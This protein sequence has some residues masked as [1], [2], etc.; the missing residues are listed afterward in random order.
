[1]KLAPLCAEV[2][3][4]RQRMAAVQDRMEGGIQGLAE[5]E[6]QLRGEIRR[7]ADSSSGFDA[8]AA[9]AAIEMKLTPLRGEVAEVRQRM[10][11]GDHTIAEMAAV[12]HRVEWDMQGFAESQ[13]QLRDEIRHVADSSSSFDASAAD[14]AIEMKL[15]PL[16]VEIAEMRQRLA[17]SDRTTLDLILAIGQMCRQA[18]G[19][20]AD[21]APLPPESAPP[22]SNVEPLL[23]GTGDSLHAVPQEPVDP[24]LESAAPAFTQIKKATA[25][26]RFPA[27]SSF[28]LAAGGLLLLHY[29]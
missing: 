25:L 24:P 27:V 26:W 18:A 12:Q 22:L 11:E 4:M 19:R 28:L 10:A 16:R 6:E 29:L 9:E 8:S 23:N 7:V 21:S 5:S 14:A 1:M 13:E 15:A 20:I 17:E 2:A 3:E